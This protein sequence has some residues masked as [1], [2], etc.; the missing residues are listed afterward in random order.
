MKNLITI[1]I[2]L[3]SINSFSQ[4]SACSCC[5]FI[6]TIDLNLSEIHNLDVIPQTIV[7]PPSGYAI[8]LVKPT[9]MWTYSEGSNFVFASGEYINIY[10]GANVLPYIHQFTDPSVTED[11]VYSS[12][13]FQ[14]YE[15]IVDGDI[16]VTSTFP[17]GSGGIGGHIV[18]QI[19]YELIQY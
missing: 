5:P 16:R 15:C 8:K 14:T 1:L 18:F 7:T 13:T 17:I 19:T 6:A 4:E 11:G 10:N 12:Y 9:I 3:L 2:T